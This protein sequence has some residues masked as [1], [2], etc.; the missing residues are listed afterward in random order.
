M[1]TPRH[2]HGGASRLPVSIPTATQKA[3]VELKATPTAPE[4]KKVG[5]LPVRLKDAFLSV[6][7][8]P[9]VQQLALHDA[10]FFNPG[11]YSDA[12]TQIAIT[13]LAV[14][15]GM[16]YTFTDIFFFA[17]VPSPTYFGASQML[18]EAALAGVIRFELLFNHRVPL[19]QEGNFVGPLA[20]SSRNLAR[21]SG[22]PFVNRVFGVQRDLGFAVY[23]IAGLTIEARATLDAVPQFP[24]TTLGVELAGFSLP[25]DAF[26]QMWRDDILGKPNVSGQPR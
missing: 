23:A 22:W 24:I 8:A 19:Q 20:G 25:D 17:T 4:S 9:G 13:G 3:R 2:G 1:N 26:Q 18:E 21:R 12:G 10:L 6:L 14:P 11:T 5:V 15:A 16:V 7:P